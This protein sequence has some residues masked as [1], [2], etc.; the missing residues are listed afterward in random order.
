MI[1]NAL[2]FILSIRFSGRYLEHNMSVSST[3]R[4]T[5]TACLLIVS[6][7]GCK[8]RLDSVNPEERQQ[9]TAFVA[10]QALLAKVATTDPSGAVR[11][12]AVNRLVDPALIAKIALED[13][14]REVRL[15]AVARLDDQIALGRI[16]VESSDADLRHAATLKLTDPIQLAR[17]AVD[18]LAVHRE[19]TGI[20][21][22]AIEALSDQA[23]LARIA[24]ESTEP[25]ARK[26]SLQKLT[27]QAARARVAIEAN[28]PEICSAA[29]E[30]IA[31][32]AALTRIA[33]EG[34]QER[35]CLAA[36][37]KLTRKDALARVAL[38]TEADTVGSAAVDAL[39]DP[40][41]LADV[42]LH[43]KVPSV[44]R[45][46]VA[47]VYDPEVLEAVAVEDG[48]EGVCQAAREGLADQAQLPWS[49]IKAASPAL[50]ART[51]AALGDTDPTLRILAGNMHAGI[52]HD[53]RMSLARMR[54]AI[55]EPRI[56]A[57]LPELTLRAAV[58]EISVNYRAGLIVPGEGVEFEI[59]QGRDS[60]ARRR[61]AS[62]FPGAV[63]ADPAQKTGFAFVPAV[64]NGDE[65]LAE[66]LRLSV[67]TQEDLA[68]LS[69]SAIPEVRAAAVRLCAAAK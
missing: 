16:A 27:D 44:R 48:D 62:V 29:I 32:P 38:R 34:K 8:P 14:D 28:D 21:H 50:R 30:G 10:D 36:V 13:W 49:A 43:G 52:A 68:E 35:I 67:F 12:A 53:A 40:V 63:V 1:P 45:A 26:A 9:A 37:E 25:W 23:Q 58:W 6:L 15:A 31:D 11:R 56:K 19:D 59:R 64:V 42:A 3:G 61:W 41:S 47:R 51:V 69:R 54:L 24:I 33:L 57:R 66:L 55:R 39:A 22:L 7:A 4:W 65:L 60:L 20:R 2:E 17:V 46:A 5:A 18:G